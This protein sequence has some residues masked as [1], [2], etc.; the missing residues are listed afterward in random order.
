M[1]IRRED[2]TR[3]RKLVG[4]WQSFKRDLARLEALNQD[5]ARI[6]RQIVAVQTVEELK[7]DQ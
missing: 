6:V 2:L 4:N 1:Y 3:A 7:G 5:L